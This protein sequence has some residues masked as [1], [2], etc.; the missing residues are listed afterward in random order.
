M[1][2][3]EERSGEPKSNRK[4]GWFKRQNAKVIQLAAPAPAVS[5]IRC[6]APPD[7]RENENSVQL[8][9]V[10][11]LLHGGSV[12]ERL[13]FLVWYL[14]AEMARCFLARLLL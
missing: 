3:T 11:L 9:S 12:A 7:V 10:P 14:V 4:D 13:G 8:D 6:P 5:G 1:L 2:T